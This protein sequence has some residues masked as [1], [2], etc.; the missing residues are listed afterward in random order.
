LDWIPP[1]FIL[2]RFQYLP[3]CGSPT[4]LASKGSSLRAGSDHLLYTA[5][6]CCS[7]F[8][9]EG[10]AGERSQSGPRSAYY[11]TTIHLALHI[12]RAYPCPVSGRM[13]GASIVDSFFRP[14]PDFV[15]LLPVDR[16]DSFP[17]PPA[18]H[19]VSFFL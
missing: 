5:L 10:L 6:Q 3:S 17:C 16:L 4:S 1:I 9:L 2:K 14:N 12:Y 7:N 19:F 13:L 11:Y 15:L 8:F 18:S